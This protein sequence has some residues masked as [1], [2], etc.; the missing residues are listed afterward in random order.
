ML[1]EVLATFQAMPEEEVPWMIDLGY[2]LTVYAR[3][4]L[5]GSAASVTGSSSALAS[6]AR[7][8]KIPLRYS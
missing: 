1:E 4:A 5:L 6:F 8:G 2:Q 3:G 7:G